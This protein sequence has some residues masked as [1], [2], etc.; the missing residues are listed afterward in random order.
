MK[1]KQVRHWTHPEIEYLKDNWGDVSIKGIALKLKRS[2]N[3]VKIKAHKIGLKNMLNYGEYITYNQLFKIIDRE[4]GIG[5]YDKKILR[6]GFPISYQ[7]VVTNKIKVVYMDRFWSWLKK[8]KHILSLKKTNK[9]DFGYEPEWVHEKRIAD[10]LAAQYKT[11]PWTRSED[12]HLKQLLAE[13][14]HGY[15]EISI[16]LKRT[17]GAIKRRM[18]DLKIMLRPLRADNHNPW[19]ENEIKKVREMYLN[20]YKSCIIAEHIDRSALAINGLLERH[21]YFKEI[22]I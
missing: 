8:N 6:A 21:N 15:R 11:S 3:A 1:K 19:Q 13:M 7:L 22:K 10:K 18:L 9:G 5:R 17:E 16:K 4:N 14:K 12:E 2:V 20:G